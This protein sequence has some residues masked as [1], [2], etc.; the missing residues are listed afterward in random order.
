MCCN[1]IL[2]IL[3]G[4]KIWIGHY[5]TD[6]Y[7]LKGIFFFY[8][9]PQCQALNWFKNADTS[10]HR[11]IDLFNLHR[12]GVKLATRFREWSSDLLEGVLHEVQLFRPISIFWFCSTSFEIYSHFLIFSTSLDIYRIF[13]LPSTL[14]DFFIF[15]T[16]FEIPWLIH[17]FFDLLRNFPIFST[18]FVIFLIFLT[19]LDVS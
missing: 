9:V 1:R 14:F 17:T 19:A 13:P 6:V 16:S 15:Y 5:I 7:Y 10:F 3:L 11:E 12:E 8:L 18:F 4:L 2:A